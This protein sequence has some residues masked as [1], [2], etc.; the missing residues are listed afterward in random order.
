MRV[1]NTYRVCSRCIMDTSDPEIVFD[2]DGV[3]NHCRQYDFLVSAVLPNNEDRQ[4][5]LDRIVENVKRSGRG[6]D[7]DCVIGVSG[8]VDSTYLAYLVKSLGLRPLAVHM[9][10]GW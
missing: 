6:R 10:N 5:R 7:Y 1:S 8:G 3:C 9:D 2:D 4:E